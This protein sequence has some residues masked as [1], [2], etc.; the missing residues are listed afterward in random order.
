MSLPTAISRKS[1]V[2]SIAV[3][4]CAGSGGVSRAVDSA[5]G[6]AFADLSNP[7]HDYWNRPLKDR[8]TR[9]KDDLESGKLPLDFSSEKAYVVSLLKALDIPVTSQIL[10][11]ST[12]SL[13][14]RMISPRNPRALYFN[15]DLFIGW[16]PGGKIEIVSIDPEIGGIFY[17]FDINLNG[18][19]P[20][21]E[22]SER[23]MNC[24][25]DD[26]TRQVPGIIIRS[27]VPGPTGGS[28]DSFRREDTGHHIPFSERFGGWH[29]TG[30]ETIDQHWGN[31]IG[32]LSQGEM[33]TTPLPPGQ[34]FD[35]ETY[36]VQTSDILPHLI[37][38]H[39]AGF[40]NR[41]LEAGYRARFYLSEGG[42]RLS[43]RVHI[44]NLKEQAD[45][46]VRYLLF[47]DEAEFPEDG[48]EGDGAFASDFGAKRVPDRRGRSLRDLNM[49]DRIFE[50]RC[51]YLI[52]SD[53]FQSLP[54]VF[55]SHVYRRLGEA[56][57]PGKGGP[58]FAHLS[59]AEKSAIREIL[60][61]TLTDLPEGW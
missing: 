20:V 17:I 52:Y 15:D 22:R 34:N 14:L 57:D 4:L 58:D 50:Y 33:S 42:G 59:N 10:V 46:L 8:F 44:D 1:A 32:R 39:Q 40:V 29:V 30:G 23:C 51:S 61:E 7:A 36:P 18:R 26:D 43:N 28:L 35:W 55:K 5:D 24:H 21:A 25:S 2:I 27:V 6:N 12:T 37:H 11:F 3:A 38:E 13:Q 60:R 54:G 49:K 45:L 16:V 56:L 19:P 48:I 9:L 41:V 53:L 31:L 47:A